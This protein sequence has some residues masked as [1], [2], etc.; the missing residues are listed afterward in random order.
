MGAAENRALVLQPPARELVPV[1]DGPLLSCATCELL[2]EIPTID[3]QGMHR[4]ILVPVE[5][6]LTIFVDDRELATLM[7]LGSAPEWL[8]A[9]Y[10]RNQQLMNDV[11]MIE[12][13][14]VDWGSA[15]ASVISRQSA[16]GGDFRTHPLGGAGCGGPRVLADFMANPGAFTLA[17]APRVRIS[18]NTLGCMLESL[19]REDSVFRAAGCVHGCALFSGADLWISAEDVSRRNAI[20][21]VGGWMALHGVSGAD[22]VLFTTGR[23]TAETVMK[24]A[25]NGIPV[26]VSRKGVTGMGFDL[27]RS[28]GMILLGR[29]TDQS[30]VCFAGADRFDVDV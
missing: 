13:I 9:G 15:A 14:F 26:L 11:T 20:D 27:G 22:K 21:T 23:I 16:Q 29:A 17:E 30:Y 2:R 18:T 5:R 6:P 8:V 24:A 7:T 4:C 19:R 3:H 10:L 25:I 12:S 1:I 28:L